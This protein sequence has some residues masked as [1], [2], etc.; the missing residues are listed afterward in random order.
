[1][2]RD[3]RERRQVRKSAIRDTLTEVKWGNK[4]SGL[5][6]LDD[7]ADGMLAPGEP[8]LTWTEQRRL[9]KIAKKVRWARE[10]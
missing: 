3:E 10:A 2:N 8:R 1:M 5:D 7:I 9:V 4:Q 6:L